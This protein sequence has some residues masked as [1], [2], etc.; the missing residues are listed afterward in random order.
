M[1]ASVANGGRASCRAWSRPRSNGSGWEPVRRAAEPAS[2]VPLEAGHGR[3][4]ARR[5]VDGGQRRRHGR[6]RAHS[7]AATSPA[8][9]APR[10]SSRSRAASG[11]AAASSDLRD[12][13][14]FVFMVPSDNPELAGVVFAEHAEHGYLA[15]PIA[16]HIIETYY[17]QKEGRPL[18][19]L[20]SCRRPCTPATP[21]GRRRG[22]RDRRRRAGADAG[23]GAQ[24][25]VFE[26]RLYHHL[27]W[28][29]LAAVLALAA[30]GVAMIFSTTG[31]AEP[32]ATGRRS[33]PSASASGRRW[34]CAWRSTTARSS[35]R[36]TGSISA[37][38]LALL[39]RAVLRRGARRLAA[40]ARSRRLQPAAVGVRQGGARA[41]LA[42]LLGECG[43]PALSNQDLLLA[44]ALTP[45]PLLLIARQPDLGT[46]VTL[47]PILGAVVFAAGLP[48]ALLCGIGVL[49][50]V[51]AAPVGVDV[52]AQD[53]QKSRIVTFLDPEQDARGA[54]YQQIQARITVGS[55][56]VLGQGL[57]GRHAGAAA[58][59]AGRAQRLHLLGAGRGAGLCR[60]RRG[61]GALPLRHHAL[62]R[63]RPAGEGPARAPISCWACSP[64][65]RSRSST[66][67]PCRRVWRRSRGS[68]CRSQL[69]RLLHDRHARRASASSST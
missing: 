40:L 8:R 19:T 9:P 69:R 28:P 32:R 39:A 3:G 6:P 23:G 61:A 2:A 1:M 67:S 13:G 17:A 47:L 34:P 66:T 11:R 64:A 16:K 5:A 44:A 48:R 31:G 7:P 35:T 42:K 22:A 24:L 62:A 59:P 49:V 38:V 56:G 52:R 4:G 60:R 27:D 53:Y 63:R 37:L 33:T 29:L 50:A 26:R 58:L 12:H 46:A 30:I 20:P 51:V 45:V 43:A 15:A 55:G 54:G 36:R 14:W 25:A 18:P 21:A 57:H 10:R 41:V 65:S 68:R